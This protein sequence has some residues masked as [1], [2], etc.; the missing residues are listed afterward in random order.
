MEWTLTVLAFLCGILVGMILS[1]R[2]LTGR[3]L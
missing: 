2:I 1:T 3:W